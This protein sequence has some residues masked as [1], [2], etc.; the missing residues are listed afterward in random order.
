MNS[1]LT[2]LALAEVLNP[3]TLINLI[4]RRVRQLNSGGGDVSRPLVSETATLGMAD[5]AL[6]EIAEGKMSFE[7]HSPEVLA[8][9]KPKR[10][11]TVKR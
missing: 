10:R 5:I 6:R 9:A 4:S 8:A 1:E 11:R 7:S 3:N 2:K